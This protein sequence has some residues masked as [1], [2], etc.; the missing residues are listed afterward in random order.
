MS[1]STLVFVFHSTILWTPV[2]NHVSSS[3]LS[4]SNAC[5]Y[6]QYTQL[7]LT[8]AHML[9]AVCKQNTHDAIK[10]TVCIEVQS[11]YIS[12]KCENLAIFRVQFSWIG[13]IKLVLIDK[14]CACA[15]TQLKIRLSCISWLPRCLNK[16][17]SYVLWDWM[18]SKSLENQPTM[19]RCLHLRS[20]KQETDF[21]L[22][23][24][25]QFHWK[26]E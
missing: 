22:F 8:A 26:W 25:W 4:L 12:L 6:P 20:L 1:S 14:R 9:E 21:E 3:A 5:K 19:H 16:E 7:L 13:A 11:F 17:M 15:Y 10:I 2:M 24:P 18:H 23:G